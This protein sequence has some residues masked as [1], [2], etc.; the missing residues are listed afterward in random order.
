MRV[1]VRETCHLFCTPF[2]FDFYNLTKKDQFDTESHVRHKM[3]G[4]WRIAYVVDQY[5]TPV[6]R[7]WKYNI[8]REARKYGRLR[9]GDLVHSCLCED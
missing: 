7:D 2:S 1:A 5:I 3:L 6:L 8:M 4:P 9:E